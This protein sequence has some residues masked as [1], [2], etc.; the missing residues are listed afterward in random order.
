MLAIRIKFHSTIPAFRRAI[1]CEPVVI[2]HSFQWSGIYDGWLA[3][4]VWLRNFSAQ[5]DWLVLFLTAFQSFQSILSPNST[6]FHTA[7]KSIV[8]EY[9]NWLLRTTHQGELGSFRWCVLTQT[10]PDSNSAETVCAF[11]MSVV[12]IP[13]PR[14]YLL[15]LASWMPTLS[16]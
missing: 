3:L 6:C 13:A 1:L 12:H 16:P 15:S 7:P 10:I 5:I 2:L 9:I 4:W 11:E 14:P 8:Y